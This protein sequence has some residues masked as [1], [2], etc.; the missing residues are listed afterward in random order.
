MTD[1]TLYKE[2][3][4]KCF[5]EDTPEDAEM[6]FKTVLSK[7]LLIAEYDENKPIAMLYLMDSDLVSN[8]KVYPFYYLYA[9]CTDPKY[10]GQGI[11]QRLLEKAKTVSQQN[12]KL[13]I[14]LKPAN[15]PLF[16]FYKKTDF[17]P[18]FKVLK[19]SLTAENF[20]CIAKQN[21]ISSAEAITNISMEEWKTKRK[22]VLNQI[23]DLYAD[24]KED[25]FTAATDGCLCA[26]LNSG[27]GV[28]YETREHTLL[29]KEALSPPKKQDE[30]IS[31]CSKL[32]EK[33]NCSN[34]EI[35]TPIS[36]NCS[37]FETFG[38]SQTRFSVLWKKN[39]IDAKDFHT[40]YHGFA[41]D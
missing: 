6:L 27:S 35:R 10:R 36:L 25:L 30:I 40:A 21:Q 26:T 12:G 1:Y 28:V 8:K 16:D 29:I 31:I 38:F 17:L 20:A 4:L 11:M 5:L 41:F 14:F 23:S 32:I 7:A 34:I 9:A 13:G 2:L 22:D 19:T 37:L 3:Y 15:Q 18:F 33:T 39:E 24:F